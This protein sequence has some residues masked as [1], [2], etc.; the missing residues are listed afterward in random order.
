MTVS[1]SFFR[2]IL[3]LFVWF[4]FRWLIG[5]LPTNFGFYLFRLM[6][7]FHFYIGR[8]K[9]KII[10]EN[11]R[12]LLNTDNST[13]KNIVKRNFENHYLDRLHIFLYSRLTTREKIEKYVYFENIELLEKELKKGKGVLLVQSH[14]G[15]V[16]ITLLALAL[17]G[18]R[19]IQIGYPSDR[20]LSWIGRRV[21]YKYRLK[22]E[23]MLPAPIIPADRYLGKVYKRLLNNGVV[24]TT[25]DGAGGGVFLGEHKTFKFLGTERIFPLGPATWAIRTGATFVP[26]F[27]IAENYNKF[28]I[29]FE[30]PVEGIY[31]DVEKDRV[32]I[33]EK[34]ISITE[35]YIKKY[36]YYW[37]FWDEGD[38]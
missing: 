14:F 7:D 3:R 36:P 18:D 23:G 12:H 37:H 29:V 33:T 4:P 20:G 17:Y 10:S 19:P 32:Y 34:F 6:G 8:G 35:D 15:P 27:I 22:Y 21:A 24:V 31:N 38:S 30:P 9:K 25:G 5:I 28:R 2:D 26:I 11:I 13:V 1:E 16:Q